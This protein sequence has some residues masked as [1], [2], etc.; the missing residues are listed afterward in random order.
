MQLVHHAGLSDVISADSAGTSDYHI[1]E[2]PHP[3]TRRILADQRITYSGTA[4]QV[5]PSDLATFD[6]VV[7]MDQH[8]LRDLHLLATNSLAQLSLL[9]SHAPELNL[10]DVP[11]PYYTG[12][13]E[14]TYRLA[15]TGAQGLLNLIC[16]EHNLPL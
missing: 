2:P 16:T 12:D 13:F 1:G 11:D 9:L 10:S 3:G 5:L 6:Y 8:N 15:H 4:R 7:A 14:Q